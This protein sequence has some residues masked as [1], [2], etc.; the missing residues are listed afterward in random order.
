MNYITLHYIDE[1]TQVK[2][3]KMLLRRN[4]VLAALAA[5]ARASPVPRTE[6]TDT[7]DIT[8]A[9]VSPPDSLRNTGPHSFFSVRGCT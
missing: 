5:A 1:P 2:P 3:L 9:S 4:F 6:S 7:A 8:V